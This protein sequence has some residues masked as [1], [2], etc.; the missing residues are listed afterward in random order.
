[1]KTFLRTL[2]LMLLCFSL[3]AGAS[4]AQPTPGGQESRQGGGRFMERLKTKLHLSD[5]QVQKLEPILKSQF[6]QLRK[7]RQAMKEQ[8]K[9]ILTAEQQAQLEQVRKERRDKG[10]TP[11]ARETPGAGQT[12]GAG[13]SPGGHPLAQLNL[14]PEQKEKL[15]ALREQNRAQMDE[16]REEL[17]AKTRTILDA[18]QQ[19]QLEEML[20]RRGPQKRRDK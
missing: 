16:M 7:N 8:M 5:D 10:Q 14:T 20:A 6:E 17:F 12:P 9:T 15:K 18:E 11:G 4:L 3:T 1:M 2:F 19:K 13:R